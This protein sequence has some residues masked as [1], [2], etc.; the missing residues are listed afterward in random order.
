MNLLINHQYI[1]PAGE[2]DRLTSEEA[3]HLIGVNTVHGLD[4]VVHTQT[5]QG[6]RLRTRDGNVLTVVALQG[7]EVKSVLAFEQV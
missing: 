6:E 1:V 5:A 3:Y 2:V 4:P 7:T